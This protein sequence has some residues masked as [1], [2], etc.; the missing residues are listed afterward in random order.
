MDK[1]SEYFKEKFDNFELPYDNSQWLRLQKQLRINKV[2]RLLK[3]AVIVSSVIFFSLFYV[4][5]NDRKINEI[6][7]N[8]KNVEIKET[9]KVQ[10]ILV[11]KNVYIDQIPV[12]EIEDIF[13]D[14][15]NILLN[16]ENIIE[17]TTNEVVII[18]TTEDIISNKTVGSDSLIDTL[19]IDT[20]TI[21]KP[22]Y[23]FPT[24]FSPNDD[25]INDEFFPIGIDLQNIKFQ[26]LIYDRWGKMTFESMSPEYKWNGKNC[27]TGIYVWILRIQ[28]NEGN[29]YTDKG[30]VTLIK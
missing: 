24:A 17:E 7:N 23:Y 5:S 18:D 27:E 12:S 10:E 4:P 9:T 3:N 1:F 29:I 30:K 26:L 16:T 14:T 2:K 11:D 20:T 19:L 21:P 25:G 22:T 28:D 6:V 13:V 15:I 8:I